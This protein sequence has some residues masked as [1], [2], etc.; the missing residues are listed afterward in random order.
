MSPAS[1]F[2]CV[3]AV[4][5]TLTQQ[6][7]AH[8]ERSSNNA[9]R[10]GRTN[11]NGLLQFLRRFL[12]SDHSFVSRQDDSAGT[13][14]CYSPDGD[15]GVLTPEGLWEV[16]IGDQFHICY[17]VTCSSNNDEGVEQ[18]SFDDMLG[19]GWECKEDGPRCFTR[20]M[21]AMCGLVIFDGTEAC[22]SHEGEVGVLDE[23]DSDK[24][25][26]GKWTI[27]IE[28]VLHICYDVSCS[29]RDDQGIE[30][31]EF[32]EMLGAGWECTTEGPRCYTREMADLC[33]DQTIF[34]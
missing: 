30:K 23:N 7:P 24:E 10:S 29:S 27:T 22:Y 13:R 2:S 1:L 21:G 5:I 32:D 25:G 8:T 26:K 4:L 17:E 15:A 19:A 6:H 18:E 28:G 33:D 9:V 31:E 34:S 20:E 12:E 16:T 3:L 11:S 14:A